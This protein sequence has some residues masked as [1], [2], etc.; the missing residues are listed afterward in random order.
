M[1]TLILTPRFTE[2][3]QSLWRAALQLGWSVERLQ[4]WRVPDELRQVGEPVL[5]LE[6]LF[7]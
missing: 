6:A 2:D 3:A 1:P 4:S 7:G 5:Y